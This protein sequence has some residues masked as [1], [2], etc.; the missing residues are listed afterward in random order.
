MEIENAGIV[1][2]GLMFIG[3][4]LWNFYGHR[5]FASSAREAE[6]IVTKVEVLE[7]KRTTVY[8]PTVRF[9]TAEGRE[10]VARIKEF[11]EVKEG[12]KVVL[13]YLPDRPEEAT[14]GSLSDLGR[15]GIGPLV[16][17]AFF[18]TAVCLIGLGLEFG[19]LDWKPR[20]PAR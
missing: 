6:A 20:G 8:Y 11:G 3:A 9:Q 1:G 13:S 19:F 7:G 18:G 12:Q 2:F 15:R 10:V 4:G 17:C 14:L 16:L 5:S